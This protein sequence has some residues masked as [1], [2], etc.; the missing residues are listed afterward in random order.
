MGT[1][2]HGQGIAMSFMEGDEQGAMAGLAMTLA[3]IMT[4]AAAPFLMPMLL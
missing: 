3:G 2:A 1:A 4:A